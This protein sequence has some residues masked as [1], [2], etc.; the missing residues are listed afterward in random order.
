MHISIIAVGRQKAGPEKS[1]FD[2]Y[3]KRI[4]WPFDV[5]EVVEHRKLSS[6]ELMNR[7]A[8]LLAAK[9]PDGAAVIVLDERGKELDSRSLAGKIEGWRDNGIR[10]TVFI[11]GGADGIHKTLR[12]RA[13]LTISLGRMTWPH[14]LVRALVAEQVYRAQC[15]LSGHPYHRD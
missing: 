10:Q 12:Q 5:V 6:A 3:A 2:T 15:I 11:I 14:M 9:I 7:E 13:D 4:T 8:D 1:L